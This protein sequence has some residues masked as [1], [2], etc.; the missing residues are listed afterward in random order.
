MDFDVDAAV[1]QARK[2]MEAMQAAEKMTPEEIDTTRLMP[3]LVPA[4]IL[5]NAWCGPYRRLR[6]PEIG[7]TWG[8]LMLG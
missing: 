5:G 2:Q 1:E 7:M 6:N 4:S 3:I 8:V